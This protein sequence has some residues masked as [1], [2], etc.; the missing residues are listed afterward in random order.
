MY[1]EI[2]ASY[3]IIKYFLNNQGRDVG[4]AVR[5]SPNL[6]VEDADLANYF[7]ILNNI[8]SDPGFIAISKTPGNAS[9]KLAKVIN[10]LFFVY[11]YQ[12]W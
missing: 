11:L 1:E 5:H 3:F 6:E 10:Y 4:K 2:S 9:Q 7:T 8:L 12:L